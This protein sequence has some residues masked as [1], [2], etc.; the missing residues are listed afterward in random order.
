MTRLILAIMASA[1][2]ALAIAL[3]VSVWWQGRALTALE[4]EN[5]SLAAQVA[6]CSARITNLLEDK[7]SDAT[8]TDPADFAVPDH[9]MRP[10]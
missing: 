4:A 5:A 9:W 10:D 3:A 1:A 2:G 6:T 7:E 8:V